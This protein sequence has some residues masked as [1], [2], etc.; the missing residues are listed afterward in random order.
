MT[1]NFF[2]ILKNFNIDIEASAYGQRSKTGIYQ[3]MK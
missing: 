1:L 3:Y 2:E